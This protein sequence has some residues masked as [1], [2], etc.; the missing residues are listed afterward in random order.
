MDR[1]LRDHSQHIGSLGEPTALQQAITDRLND[2]L[3]MMIRTGASV[4][5]DRGLIA[6]G[7]IRLTIPEVARIATQV[8]AA[9]VGS[10]ASP[11]DR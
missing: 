7:V 8:A 6:D 1:R 3:D 4:P 5:T 2:V 10:T 9:H 11:T